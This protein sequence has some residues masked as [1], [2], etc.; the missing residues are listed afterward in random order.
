MPSGK[1]V[2]GLLARIAEKT[3]MVLATLQFCHG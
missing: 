3:E 2:D 1:M